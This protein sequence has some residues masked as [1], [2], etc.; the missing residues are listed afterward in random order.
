VKVK[1]LRNKATLRLTC[2]IAF[3]ILAAFLVPLAARA[4]WASPRAVEAPVRPAAWNGWQQVSLNPYAKGMDFSPALAAQGS[5]VYA[6]WSRQVD[7]GGDQDY[8]PHYNFSTSDGDMW[9]SLDRNIQPTVPTSKTVNVDMALDSTG[10]PHFVWAENTV[11][12]SYTLYYS[13]THISAIQEIAHANEAIIPVIAVGNRVHVAWLQGK[14]DIMYRSKDIAGGAWDPAITVRNSTKS[15]QDPN[16][17]VDGS[18]VHVVWSDGV[19]P[20]DTDIMYTNNSDWSGARRTVYQGSVYVNGIGYRPDI[21]ARGSNV[22]VVWCAYKTPGEQYVRFGQSTNGG[23]SWSTSQSISGGALA[24]NDNSPKYLRPG[25]AVDTNG[26]LHVAFNG[27]AAG[28]NGKEHIFYVS[29][30]QGGSWRTRQNVTSLGLDYNNTTPAIATS[31]EYVHL[32]WARQNAPPEPTSRYD[33]FYNRAS[34][35]ETEGPFLP[36]IWKS[37]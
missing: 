9:G 20:D 19:E 13:S 10:A 33:V 7:P 34:I 37:F 25:I 30:K 29:R 15:V 22:Y 26:K 12:P 31:G 27:S 28:V 35:V 3:S 14:Y 11:T 23:S 4:R 17:A 18:T 16:I 5:R 36:I 21:V 24:A 8:D 32:I 6:M 2:I 1:K